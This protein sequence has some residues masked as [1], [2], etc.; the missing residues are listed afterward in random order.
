MNQGM[1]AMKGFSAYPKAPALLEPHHHVVCVIYRTFFRGVTSLQ[2]RG[3]CVLQPQPTWQNT[4][5]IQG[6][7]WH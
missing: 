3:P 2:R 1:M 6:Q 7:F 4:V 5:L